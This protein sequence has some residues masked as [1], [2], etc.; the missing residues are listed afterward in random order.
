M[1]YIHTVEYYSNI[2][3][4]DI[5]SFAAM[6]MEFKSIIPSE[7]TKSTK[8]MLDKYSLINGY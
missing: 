3:N 4:R 1:W 7:V 8:D 2:K 5:M 6:W